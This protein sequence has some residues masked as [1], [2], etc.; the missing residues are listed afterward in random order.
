M[1]NIQHILLKVKYKKLFLYLFLMFVLVLSPLVFI[2]SNSLYEVN[3]S[4]DTMFFYSADD[5]YKMIDIIGQSGRRFYLIT[6]W[7]FDLLYPLIYGV[8]LY[9]LMHTFKQKQTLIIYLPFTAVIFDYL[10]N[11]LASLLTVFYKSHINFLVYVL[12][13][14]SLLKWLFLI[15]SI[16]YL[17]IAYF[18]LRNS[19][20][21]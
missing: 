21:I 7:T 13:V 14:F 16:I 17:L 9:Q 12:Q 10:E 3:F 11:T 19:N 4:P 5:F 1:K 6:R 8:F 18:D 15:L 2:L 20:K